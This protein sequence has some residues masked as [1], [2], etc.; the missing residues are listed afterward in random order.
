MMTTKLIK[1][2]L[3]EL[4]AIDERNRLAAHN[5]MVIYQKPLVAIAAADDPLFESYRD[6]GIIGPDYIPPREWL[7]GASSVVSYFMPFSKP[8]RESNHEPGFPSGEWLSSRIDG[9]VFNDV[10]R[11]ALADFLK[12]LG[13]EALAPVLD[14]RFKNFGV[15]SN[16]SERHAAYA[17]G[18]GTFG[19][20]KSFITAAGCAGRFGS[21]ITSLELTPSPRPYADHTSNCPWLTI[22]A[23]G[24]CIERCPSGAITEA[25]KDKSICRHYL[26]DVIKPRFNPLHGCG[27]C[28]TSVPCEDGIPLAD[29]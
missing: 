5:G 3:D 18:L 19:L 6:P 17:A 2:F 27:K 25:G 24:A 8:V 22:G 16:W 15:Y 23:C 7:P 21:A 1:D 14:S 4:F 28:Q 11:A 9:E 13:G 20:N 10:V 29:R 26:D 12:S